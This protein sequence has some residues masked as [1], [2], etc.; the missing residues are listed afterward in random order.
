MPAKAGLEHD[1]ASIH[2][3]PV[4][5]DHWSDIRALHA[6][7]LRHTLAAIVGSEQLPSI[8]AEIYEPDY[9]D[10]LMTWD[11][12]TA[13]IGAT[14]IGTAGWHPSTDQ[15]Y[16]ARIV[17]VHV[18]PLYTRLGIGRRLIAT[19]EAR[20]RA[21]G[22]EIIT[23]RV[24]PISLGFFEALG[25]RRTSQGVQSVGTEHGLPAIYLRK[26]LTAPQHADDSA[27]GD[28]RHPTDSLG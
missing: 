2:L 20:A 22:F 15:G 7:S 12:H 3:R 11:L 13:W 19:T 8:V 9:T 1:N 4:G 23:A 16:S 25:Y 24:L 14:L 26:Q 18:A 28:A 21:A 6:A 17:S 5:L 10:R 27:S